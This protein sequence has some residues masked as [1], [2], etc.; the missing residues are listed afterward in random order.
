M[1]KDLTPAIE[2]RRQDPCFM[3]GLISCLNA[4]QNKNWGE[5]LYHIGRKPHKTR[6]GA[7]TYIIQKASQ[8]FRSV[9]DN[10]SYRAISGRHT[11]TGLFLY[12]RAQ[13]SA[14]NHAG[15]PSGKEEHSIV[16]AGQS[17]GQSSGE[18]TPQSFEGRSFPKNSFSHVQDTQDQTPG[19]TNSWSRRGSLASCPGQTNASVS[20]AAK[21]MRNR[22]RGLLKSCPGHMR[23]SLESDST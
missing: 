7:R 18:L 16:A 11:P 20:F 2:S 22:N 21:T 14:P 9:V 6:I 23:D 8:S 1:N 13:D 15:S 12:C 4:S 17:H 19:Y 3:R 10:Q 5:D